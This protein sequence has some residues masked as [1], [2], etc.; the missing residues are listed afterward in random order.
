[1]QPHEILGVERDASLE[2]IR[3]AYLQRATTAHPDAGG[4]KEGFVALR[5]AYEAMVDWIETGS[6]P[7]VETA[8]SEPADETEPSNDLFEELKRQIHEK[9]ARELGKRQLGQ[10]T[11]SR[12]AF[13]FILTIVLTALFAS[14]LAI[15]LCYDGKSLDL[16]LW[17]FSFA[18]STAF[19][20]YLGG[21]AA[22]LGG[23]LKT[24]YLTVYRRVIIFV[25]IL[26]MIC[27]SSIVL[28]WF[29]TERD[30]KSRTQIISKETLPAWWPIQSEKS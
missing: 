19:F 20:I 28:D 30:S 22:V 1:M 8:S 23:S 17:T 18:I 12:S 7:D 9:L 29:G 10:R 14:G 2:V 25:S 21:T 5:D 16:A 15:C 26:P 24:D 6:Y 4:S 3:K 11:S 27:A 13:E